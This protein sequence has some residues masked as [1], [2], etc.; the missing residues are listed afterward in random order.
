MKPPFSR[1]IL[2]TLCLALAVEA[3]VARAEEVVRNPT[4][5]D[6]AFMVRVLGGS[7]ELAQKVVTSTELTPGKRTLIGFALTEDSDRM[8]LLVGHLL[9]ETTTDRYQHV[10][11]ASC[12]GGGGFPALQAVFF[13]RTAKEG[14]RDW[15]S[16]VAGISKHYKTDGTA[17]AAEFYRLKYAG[18]E[19]TVHPLATE[20]EVQHRRYGPSRRRRHQGPGAGAFQDGRRGQEDPEQDGTAAIGSLHAPR[21]PLVR[22]EVTAPRSPRQRASNALLRFASRSGKLS[23]WELTR[24]E[25]AS[26][27]SARPIR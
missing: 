11:F 4:E 9:I 21:P 3:G 26:Y 6:D 14:G 13:A 19:T 1:W 8:H 5:T 15:R 25:S 27:I 22:A 20:Q 24:K 2:L 7:V 23:S 18:A 16:C 17:Y 12:G 10:K